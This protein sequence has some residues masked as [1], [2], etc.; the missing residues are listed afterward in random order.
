M[1]RPSRSCTE[2]R[3]CAGAA[4]ENR[5]VVDGLKGDLSFEIGRNP[6]VMEMMMLGK[7][8]VEIDGI[9]AGTELH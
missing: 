6:V 7:N 5:I 1:R 4:R 9:A 8:P 2:R 3:A